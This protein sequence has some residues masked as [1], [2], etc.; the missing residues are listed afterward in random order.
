[1]DSTVL[2]SATIDTSTKSVAPDSTVL[3]SAVLDSTTF[4]T[5]ALDS[6]IVD[7]L[8]LN[9]LEIPQPDTTDT[10]Q[11]E[12]KLFKVQPWEFHA[13]LGAKLT[14]TDSTLRW[15]NWPDWTYKLNRDPGII[16]YR[17]GTNI[18][19]NAVQRHAHEPRHQ[20]L[21]WEGISLNDPVSGSVNWALI[22]QHKISQFYNEDLG[23]EHRST[24]YL[25][26]Y[27]LNKPL[28]RLIYS[29]SKF[30]YRNLEFEVSH[31]LSQRTNIEISYWD[32]RSGGEYPNSEIT[33]RQIYAK[34]SHHLDRRR[35]LKLSYI[36]NTFDIGQPFGYNIQNLLTYH[37][38]RYAATADQSSALSAETSSLLS[39]NYYQRS[40]DTTKAVDNFHAGLF[41]KGNERTLNA[42]TDSTGYSLRSLGA[43]AQKW[44]TIGGL[45]FEGYGSYEQFFNGSESEKSLPAD[46]WSLLKAEG[47]ISLDY[48]KFIDLYGGAEFR[49][50]SDG[51]QSYRFNGKSDITLGGFTLSAGASSGTIMP[52]PQQLYW[53]SEE[54]NGTPDLKNEKIQEARGTVSYNFTPDTRFGI[55][56]QH[57]DVTDGIMMGDS[58]FTN[59]GSYAS[60]SVTAFF[61]WDMTHFELNGSATVHRFTDSYLEPT[62]RIPMSPKERIWLKGG[63]YWKGYLFDR[64]TYVKAGVSGMMAPFRYQADSYNPALNYWQPV[65]D[66]QE[67]PL[68]NRLDVDISARVRSIMFILRWENVLDDVHELGYFETAQYPM[69][70][71]QF[72]F[73]VRAL[74]RN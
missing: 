26:Q 49:L 63:A 44:W 60:Q 9:P 16:T 69:S 8:F 50:R 71:R 32:R 39:L 17:L 70:Q 5:T 18:R 27:Y 66:D 15:Q 21:Y 2:D 31:N 42:T 7:S 74:F 67:L 58:T 20:Q 41:Y 13:P 54:F 4:K 23:T 19:S 37:F 12:K 47:N 34:A 59:V 73:G 51:F 48:T 10:T 45:T 65:S 24:F 57:K 64:A 30:T 14:E 55:R 68:F 22:P 72:I 56:G 35:Y 25:H 62:N 40:A 3:D 61:D 29:E 33:G 38:D 28:S 36:N 43:N 6:A 46:D 11:A 53:D 52:T 1:V